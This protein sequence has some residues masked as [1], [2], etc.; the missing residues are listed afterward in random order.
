MSRQGTAVV[1]LIF[2][3]IA[4][5][6]LV[7]VGGGVFAQNTDAKD[8][9]QEGTTIPAPAFDP[10]QDV[11]E[12]G[13]PPLVGGVPSEPPPFVDA[14]PPSPDQAG[15]D[16]QSSPTA[17]TITI[18]PESTQKTGLMGD[19]QK[20]V[21]VLG[22]VSPKPTSLTYSLN[23]APHQNLRTGADSRRLAQSG[24]FNIELDYTKL[25]QG[26]NGVT[27]IAKNAQGEESQASVMINYQGGN[28]TWPSDEYTFDWS[29]ASRIDDL[30]RLVDGNWELD[31]DVVR[32]VVLDYDRI[33]AIGDLSWRDYTVTVPIKFTGID[34]S[35]YDFP[36]NGPGVG[37]IVRWPGHYD[38][39]G[40]TAPLEGWR[41]LGAFAWYRWSRALVDQE[42]V[43]SEA[44]QMFRHQGNPGQNITE[45][46]KLEMGITY[47]FKVSVESTGNANPP[48]NYRFKV[49]D[50]S[51]TEPSEWDIEAPGLVGE[52]AG[53]GILLVA[54]H[55]D[56]EFGE[57]TVD[58][59]STLSPPTLTVNTSGSGSGTV[60]VSPSSQTN[61][62]RFGEDVR[63]TAVPDS[64]SIFA[65]WQ[66]SVAGSANPVWV[67]MF[68]NRTVTAEFADA[69]VGEPVSDDFGSCVLNPRWEYIDPLG[70][71]SLIMNGSR[72]Q[73]SVPSGTKHDMWTNNRNAPRVMQDISNEDFE[74]DVKFESSMSSMYQLQGVLVEADSTNFL[75]YN[76]QHDGTG[77]Y[78]TAYSVNNNVATLHVNDP[79][80]ISPPMYLRTNRTGNT[81]TLWYSGNGQNWTEAT[82][83]TFNLDASSAGVFAGNAGPNPAMV[84][85]VDYFF[86]TSSPIQ[87]Q[88]NGQTVAVSTAGS[89]S[90]TVTQTPQK[91][92]YACNEPVTLEAIPAS[93]SYFTGWSGDLSGSDNPVTINVTSDMVITANFSADVYHTLDITTE[94]QGT[95]GVDPPGSQFLVGTEV[96]LLATPAAGH[97]FVRWEGAVTG[98]SNPANL[99]MD[100]NKSVKAVFESNDL[101]PT[102]SFIFLPTV[103]TSID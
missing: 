19:P 39:G 98:S 37:L 49:W 9:A 15:I 45:D 38:D 103:L 50:A 64:G 29:T 56:A 35:G 81:W 27:I 22:T 10:V 24:D 72:L 95:V 65:G 8:N 41:R 40:N 57:V 20:W 12:G 16:F 96:T 86:N 32:P 63:L 82:Q 25:N 5:T 34:E 67:E 54:H 93:G 83:F 31:G 46:R 59:E 90:G 52:P 87:P 88:G 51:K 13:M 62:Y 42:F 47:N 23:G 102:E 1:R 85:L 91:A 48:S 69:T 21:N 36:S 61:T 28:V 100:G 26:S 80:T 77:Y 66:G 71:S 99:V 74:F 33:I 79:I 94:G 18:W 58:L 68:S 97:R 3:I 60:E 6:L 84:S 30:G 75:R 101:P 7:S 2:L 70:H 53:G 4:A 11:P 92:S 55:V 76:F 73:I 17:P 14:S 78:I 43:Y 89:G 44:L